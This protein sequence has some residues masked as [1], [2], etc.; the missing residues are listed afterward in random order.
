MKSLINGKQHLRVYNVGS[1]YNMNVF[2]MINKISKIINKNNI[3]I[4]ILNSSKNEILSQKLNYNKISKELKWK[5]KTNLENGL[6]KTLSWY[7]S[8][9]NFFKDY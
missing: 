9:I 7:K 8:N 4:K 6:K 1:K 3:K 5:Q 2:K